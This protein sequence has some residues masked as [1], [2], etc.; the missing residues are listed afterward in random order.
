MLATW[1]AAVAALVF[2][3]VL[4][5]GAT[6]LTDSGLSITEWAPVSGVVPPLD[7]AGWALAF[8]KY[9]T[10]TE[11]Q[12]VNS[13]MTLEQFK[14][15]YW[16][17]WGHRMLGRAIGLAVLIPLAVLWAIG[18]LPAPWRGR[19]L[20]VF[21]AVCLQGVIGWWMV[22]SGLVNRVDVSQLRLAVHLTMASAIFAYLVWL[23]R[24]LLPFEA[25][26]VPSLAPQAAGLTVLVLAQIFLG[27]LVAGLDAGMAYN[28]WPKMDGAWL[29]GGL[30]VA[31][32]VWTNFIDNAKTVQFVHRIGAYVLLAAA[33]AHAVHL[34]R[35]APSGAHVKRA[36]LLAAVVVMQ[37]SI[38]VITL[39]M[40]VPFFWALLH[41]GWAMVILA[42]AV[43]HWRA[44]SA[45]VVGAHSHRATELAHAA[46]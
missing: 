18:R 43:V 37:A 13:A 38:G 10:T 35:T 28:T 1:F 20:I 45:P 7:A 30:L 4:V 3:I 31:D 27:G 5:G 12:T 41:Q 23:V 46:A 11:Y 40:Q 17:E 19:A 32:P 8:D 42:V 2:A 24:S 44:L 21:A 33:I 26:R 6:R 9:K 36:F 39:V 22:K 25:A 14:V 34:W 29:P 16:W 15:I